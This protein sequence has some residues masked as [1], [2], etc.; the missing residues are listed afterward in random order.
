MNL[1]DNNKNLYLLSAML[2]EEKECHFF[3]DVT[4]NTFQ[5]VGIHSSCHE[6]TALKVKTDVD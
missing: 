6:F 3:G 5:M 1:I 2:S 4:D